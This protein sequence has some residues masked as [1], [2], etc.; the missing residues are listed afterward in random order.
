M[1]FTA[2]YMRDIHRDVINHI[3]EVKARATVLAH[4]DE[5]LFFARST[6]PR[7]SSSITTGMALTFSISVFK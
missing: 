2:D 1:I 7:T 4:E 5:V 6:R 3:D